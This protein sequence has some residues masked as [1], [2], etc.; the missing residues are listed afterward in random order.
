MHLY[1][2]MYILL[3]RYLGILSYMFKCIMLSF[4]SVILH[5]KMF[6]V[7]DISITVIVYLCAL[8][9]FGDCMGLYGVRLLIMNYVA[10]KSHLCSWDINR[11]LP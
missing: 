3:E 2:V 10:V 9:S 1:N 11:L 4:S 6:C 5:V 7:G 8:P